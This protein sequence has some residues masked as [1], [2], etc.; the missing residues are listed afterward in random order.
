MTIVN[1]SIHLYFIIHFMSLRA[2]CGHWE[3]T[4][5]IYTGWS[6]DIYDA[7][8]ESGKRAYILA[9]EHHDKRKRKDGSW[10]LEHINRSLVFYQNN[11]NIFPSIFELSTIEEYICLHDSAE[12]SD[13]GIKDVYD[14]FWTDVL[15]AILWMS[16]P[17]ERV[18]RILANFVLSLPEDEKQKFIIFLSIHTIIETKTPS[19]PEAQR[20]LSM[21]LP[22]GEWLGL[23]HLF[24]ERYDGESKPEN[25]K[26]IFADW[27]FQGQIE[28]MSVKC[29]FAKCVE[30]LDNLTDTKWLE[31][32][33]WEKSYKKTLFTTSNVYLPRL[34]CLWWNNLYNYMSG[35]AGDWRRKMMKYEPSILFLF[36]FTRLIGTKI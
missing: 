12:D 22:S 8:T 19:D 24:K 31:N 16:E 25:K 33:E 15:I 5:L 11:P 26:D 23:W 17:K 2:A 36:A 7:L 30:R 32:V 14:E 35:K 1:I 27:I 4:P 29:F 18:R 3:V 13:N 9:A 10:Y 6:S 21:L 34:R 28:N 20:S